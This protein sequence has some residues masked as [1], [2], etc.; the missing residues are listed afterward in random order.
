MVVGGTQMNMAGTMNMDDFGLQST[1]KFNV[2]TQT[3]TP[4]P[5]MNFPRWYPTATIL[6]DGRVLVTSGE[7][8]GSNTDAPI[9]EI[10]SSATNTW[11]ALSNAQFPYKFFYPHVFQLANGTVFVPSTDQGPIISQ[12]LDLNAQTWTPVG[13]TSPIDSGV[14]IQYLPGKFLKTGHSTNPGVQPYTQSNANA[15]TIDMTAANPTW[16]K[17]ASMAFPRTYH[18]MTSLPDGTVLVTGGGTDTNP[19]DIANAILATELWNPAT[20]AWTTLAD[21]NS[22]RIYHSEAILLPDARV[23]ISGGGRFNN[24]DQP[25]YQWSAEF[26]SPPYLFKGAR[27]TI[28]SVST[29]APPLGGNFTVTTPNAAN[30]ASVSL[31]RFGSATHTFNMSQKFIPLSFTAG[32]GLLSVNAPANSILAPPG[33]YMLFILDGNGIPSK[34][35]IVHF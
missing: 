35:A 9:S 4:L 19:G 15:Y 16:T 21:I 18:N 7:Q 25:F 6:S 24:D 31:I 20:G 26:F 27:P 3:W 29:T 5:P 22:P 32:A 12:I 14:A 17:I 33:N 28:S 10:Y 23:L 30:I 34:A 11:T 1:S 2:L 8:N 13:G